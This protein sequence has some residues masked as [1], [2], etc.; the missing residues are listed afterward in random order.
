M[1]LF[2]AILLSEEMK[3]SVTGTMHE[4]KK[5]GVRGSYVPVTEPACNACIYRRI[6]GCCVSQRSDADIG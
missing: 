1:R 4:L 6:Q 3:K 2:F 5:A